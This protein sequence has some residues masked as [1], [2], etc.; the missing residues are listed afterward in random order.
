[1]TGLPIEPSSQEIAETL[2]SEGRL[3]LGA[4]PGAGK[5]TRVPLALAGLLDGFDAFPGKIIMLEPRRIAARM[6]AARMAQTLGEGLGQ[7]IGLSTRIDRRVS[8]DTVVEVMTDGLF[9]R[10][11]LGDPE[12]NGVSAVIFDEIHERSLSADLG[13]ALAQETQAALRDDLHLLAMSATLDTASM[14]ER[15]R[16][17]SREVAVA[18]IGREFTRR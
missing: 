3:I 18:I 12:L 9:T 2:R 11:L 10:R 13:L 4:P 17:T 1:M 16:S 15:L 6:A 14:A 5:T 8:N 7:R